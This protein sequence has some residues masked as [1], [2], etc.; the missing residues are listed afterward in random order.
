[1]RNFGAKI[2]CIS[3]C[4]DEAGMTTKALFFLLVAELSYLMGKP[5]ILKN[6]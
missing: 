6:L 1:M 4:L 3:N 5:G 2:S